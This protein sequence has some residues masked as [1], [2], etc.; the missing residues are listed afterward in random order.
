LFSYRKIGDLRVMMEVNVI[1]VVVY[2][3]PTP[4]TILTTDR[5]IDNVS[6]LNKY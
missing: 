4:D 2:E 1:L 5:D 3:A 6:V